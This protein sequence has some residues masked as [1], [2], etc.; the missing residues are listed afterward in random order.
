MLRVPRLNPRPKRNPANYAVRWESGK[1]EDH[2][3]LT[4]IRGAYPDSWVTSNIERLSSGGAEGFVSVVT[5]DHGESVEAQ[6]MNRT[7]A[8]FG[9]HPDQS[10][11]LNHLQETVMGFVGGPPPRIYYAHFEMKSVAEAKAFVDRV[12]AAVQNSHDKFEMVGQPGR[13]RIQLRK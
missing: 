12:I 5:T 3:A 9:I 1:Y 4:P 11:R 13:E 10:G 7:L 8:Q 2:L 6:E